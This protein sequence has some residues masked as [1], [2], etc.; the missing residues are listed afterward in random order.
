MYYY[1]KMKKGIIL[2]YFQKRYIYLEEIFAMIPRCSKCILLDNSCLVPGT[3]K[4]TG[5]EYTFTKQELD[6]YGG[7]R[8]K[9]KKRTRKNNL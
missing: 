5:K 6:S 2:I 7:T 3:N 8:K 4:E 9:R 1:S